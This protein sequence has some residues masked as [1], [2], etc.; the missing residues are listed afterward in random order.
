MPKNSDS[1]KLATNDQCLNKGEGTDILES[2]R[3][4]YLLNDSWAMFPHSFHD[5]QGGVLTRYTRRF[6]RNGKGV[7]EGLGMMFA[8]FRQEIIDVSTDIGMRRLDS[9]DNLLIM[10]AFQGQR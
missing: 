7:N 9:S 5:T 8:N 3:G 4:T 6:R 2:R 10:S 1:D